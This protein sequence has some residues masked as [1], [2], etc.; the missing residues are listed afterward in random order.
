M[1]RS[2]L[3]KTFFCIG[4]VWYTIVARHYTDN[5]LLISRC[6]ICTWRFS[7]KCLLTPMLHSSGLGIAIVNDFKSI[8]GDRELGHHT[9]WTK[10][11]DKINAFIIQYCRRFTIFTSRVRC[12]RCKMAHS[13]YNI[14]WSNG[15]IF[16]FHSIFCNSG[17]IDVTQLAVAGYL[18]NIAEYTYSFI[19]IALILPQMV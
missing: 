6:K 19:L 7:S 8:E 15:C 5:F 13:W 2:W 16:Y 11:F 9:Y 4:N 17:T 1:F 3:V 14:Y 18:F 12:W 10:L